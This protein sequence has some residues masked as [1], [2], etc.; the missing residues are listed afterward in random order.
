MEIH[1]NSVHRNYNCILFLILQ[2]L[3]IDT[4]F[5]RMCKSWLKHYNYGVLAKMNTIYFMKEIG[6]NVSILSYHSSEHH[7][8]TNETSRCVL[9]IIFSLLCYF[10]TFSCINSWL[11]TYVSIYIM[12]IQLSRRENQIIFWVSFITFNCPIELYGPLLVVL[13]RTLH[14]SQWACLPPLLGRAGRGAR[15]SG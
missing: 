14:T 7:R 8:P 1:S 3:T 9:I 15:A 12:K 2:I 10:V 5:Q 4:N 11:Y 13:L 6:S